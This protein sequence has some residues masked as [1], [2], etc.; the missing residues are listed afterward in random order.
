MKGTT[1]IITMMRSR[2]PIYHPTD[3][4]HHPGVKTLTLDGKPKITI[5]N[6]RTGP[7]RG[8]DSRSLKIRT[9]QDYEIH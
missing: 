4:N 1:V 2:E 9:T 6:P 7:I 8:Q 5:Y 3:H